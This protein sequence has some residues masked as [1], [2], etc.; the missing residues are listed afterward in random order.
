[1]N[2]LVSGFEPFAEH[3]T[4]PTTEILTTLTQGS[5]PFILNT[6]VLPVSF[7]NAFQVLESKIELYQPDVVLSLG[8]SGARD[9]ICLE[10]Q[11]Y[12]MMDC[13]VPDNDG[14]VYQ[15]TAIDPKGEEYLYSTLPMEELLVTAKEH[16]LNCELSHDAGAYVCNYLMYKCLQKAHAFECH[17]GFI[18]LPHF[19]HIS[20]S[21]QCRTLT[22]LLN[23]IQKHLS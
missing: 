2:I 10:R 13:K 5:F 3:T 15:K 17:Y 11:A 23:S 22:L 1:M 20:H 7:A 18:H 14:V 9:K 16:K 21:E 4:N 8:L 6:V 12:N 19:H